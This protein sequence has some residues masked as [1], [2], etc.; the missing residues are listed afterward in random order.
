V[1]LLPRE[2]NANTRSRLRN[3]R[4]YR[5]D[6]ARDRFTGDEIDIADRHQ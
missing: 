5:R 3:W 4:A 6:R 2:T 1:T